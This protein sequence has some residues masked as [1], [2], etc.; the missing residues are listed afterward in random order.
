MPIPYEQ[1]VAVMTRILNER[2]KVV[3]Q[4]GPTVYSPM[5]QVRVALDP[6][7]NGWIAN[8]RVGGDL[9]A[10][11]DMLALVI[12]DVGLQAMIEMGFVEPLTDGTSRRTAWEKLDGE[13]LE[14]PQHP[15]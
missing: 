1:A 7:K 15:V 11:R 4:D 6:L 12:Q 3:R 8:E 13:Q 9:S 2:C 14:G 10:W 5:V